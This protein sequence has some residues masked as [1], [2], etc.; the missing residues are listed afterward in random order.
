MIEKWRASVDQNETYPALL[1]DLSKAFDLIAK[2]HAYGCDLSS[3]KMLNTY[4][5]NR[6]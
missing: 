4:L 5:R 3:L 2:F 1:T 6:H